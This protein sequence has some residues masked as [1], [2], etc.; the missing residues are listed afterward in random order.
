M[1]ITLDRV[2]L[3]VGQQFLLGLDHDSRR[4]WH[5]SRILARVGTMLQ[6]ECPP[7]ALAGLRGAPGSEVILDTWRV[8]D[9]R[10]TLRGRVVSVEAGDTPRLDVELLDGTRVQHREYFRVPVSINAN[11]AWVESDDEHQP[12]RR[13]RLHLRD[14]SA[15]GI[16]ARSNEILEPLTTIR[17]RI[18]LPGCPAPL[19]VRARV[20]RLTDEPGPTPWPYEVGAAFLEVEPG[21]REEIIRFALRLQAE[22]LKRGVI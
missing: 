12:E 8:M 6:V 7:E 15:G 2:P 22:D 4:E 16:R 11:E 10:Y 9:A 17:M 3:Q 18:T 13:V 19:T 14:I 5:H 20:V 1:T 21:L